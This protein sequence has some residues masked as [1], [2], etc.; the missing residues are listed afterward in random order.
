[1]DGR[2]LGSALRGLRAEKG[3]SQAVLARRA[4]LSQQHLSLIERDASRAEVRTVE[5]V[6]SA[7]G[8]TLTLSPSLA[9]RAE[10]WRRLEEAEAGFAQWTT[11]AEDL[12]R[13]SELAGIY[14]S[15]YPEP[16]APEERREYCLALRAR[17]RRAGL[18]G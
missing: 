12:S 13:V 18:P 17:M 4:G 3:W 7:L 16:P 1:M 11:P 6:L 15:R 14:L 9:A 10:A 8:R 5:R 2:A